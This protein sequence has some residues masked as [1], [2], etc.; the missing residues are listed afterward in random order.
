MAKTNDE[1]QRKARARALRIRI[2]RLKPG[3]ETAGAG[4]AEGDG[5]G[6]ESPHEF[7]ERR[8]REL[9]AEERRTAAQSAGASTR[10]RKAEK[11]PTRG[12]AKKR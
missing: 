5:P 3:G 11:K 7:V 2:E 12:S 6:Q 1:A 8:M 10:A 4:P 9:A